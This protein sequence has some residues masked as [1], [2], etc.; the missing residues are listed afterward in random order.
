MIIGEI[1]KDVVYKTIEIDLEGIQTK[2]DLLY[3]VS[4]ELNFPIWDENNWDAFNDWLRFIYEPFD[5]YKAVKI[6]FKNCGNLHEDVKKIFFKIL[7]GSA[8]GDGAGFSSDNG[9]HVA[10][11][12]EILDN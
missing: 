10:C 5:K 4:K 7:Q 9:Y 6:V 11:Y 3:K 8:T 1:N 2:K 12:Y